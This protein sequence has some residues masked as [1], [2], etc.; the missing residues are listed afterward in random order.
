MEKWCNNYDTDDIFYRA[1]WQNE[2]IR[3]CVSPL[4]WLI[5]L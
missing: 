4:L 5:K 2:E 3:Y 1:L